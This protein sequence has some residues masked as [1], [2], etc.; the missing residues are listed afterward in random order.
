M[1][2]KGIAIGIGKWASEDEIYDA[3]VKV[4]DDKTFQENINALSELFR[5]QRN[6]PMD[7][8]IWLLEYMSKTNGGKHLLLSS[9]H[10]NLIQYHSLDVI[11]F[12]LVAAFAISKFLRYLINSLLFKPKRQQHRDRPTTT[13]RNHQQWKK[14]KRE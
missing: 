14:N 13:S 12:V 6:H 8:T 2:E 4:R 1:E 5:M 11:F 10:L 9:R 7:D 3:I